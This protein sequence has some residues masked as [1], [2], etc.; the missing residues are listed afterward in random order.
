MKAIFFILYE[1]FCGPTTRGPQK[2]GGPG[3]L[4]RLNPRFLLHCLCGMW[5]QI[6]IK[7]GIILYYCIDIRIGCSLVRIM[8]IVTYLFYNKV[9]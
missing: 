1:N 5:F 7:G 4:N 6:E 3:S 9:C 8:H 2:F